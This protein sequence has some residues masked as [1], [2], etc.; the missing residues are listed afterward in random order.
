MFLIALASAKRVSMLQA[1]PS[2]FY[3]PDAWSQE[4]V[5]FAKDLLV[6]DYTELVRKQ[7]RS[8]VRSALVQHPSAP[9]EMLSFFRKNLTD[10]GGFKTID[11][12]DSVFSS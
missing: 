1:L 11:S 7:A 4:A 2:V 6:K 5:D 3:H 9:V 12:K 10:A 8:F